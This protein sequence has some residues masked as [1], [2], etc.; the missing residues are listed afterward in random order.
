MRP[1]LEQELHCIEC[2]GTL[3]LQPFRSAAG[4]LGRPEVV[5]GSLECGCGAVFPIIAGVPRLVAGEFTRTWPGRYPGFFAQYGDRLGHK[6]G[7]AVDGRNGTAQAAAPVEAR[8]AQSFAY[9]WERFGALR[10]E[11]EENFWGYMSPLTAAD[12]DGQRILDAGCG[13][14]RHA[15]HAGRAG[16]EVF[17]ADLGEAVDVAYRNTAALANVHVVQADLRRLPFRSESFDR[18]YSLGVLHHLPD[19]YA[20]FR[21]LIPY[22]RVGGEMRVYL[23]W[24]LE[25]APAWQR[26]LLAGVTAARRVTTRLP[27]RLL[28]ALSYPIAGAAFAGFVLPYRALRSWPATRRLAE[29]LPL[30]QYADYPFR[31]CV[32]DQFDRFSAPIE[33]RYTRAEV[34]AWLR[35]GGLENPEVRAHFGWVGTARRSSTSVALSPSRRPAPA[36]AEV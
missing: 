26:S 20:A 28:H 15:Y 7:C 14:G 6:M 24:A 27:H 11:W 22:L 10:P 32:N 34:M 33:R 9:E 13:S 23:Y 12:L 30:R 4:P 1:G 29:Q 2:G 21:S 17:A 8:T 5:D 19:P 3:R 18:V 35:G 25:H 16:A 36:L 31:V